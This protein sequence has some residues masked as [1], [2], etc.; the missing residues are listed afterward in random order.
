MGV[1]ILFL[2]LLVMLLFG[3]GLVLYGLII[4]IRGRVRLTRTTTLHGVMALLAGIAIMVLG[5]GLAYLLW[6]MGRY[7]PH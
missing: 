6:W 7:F 1:E 2:Y 5:F 4:S 3:P